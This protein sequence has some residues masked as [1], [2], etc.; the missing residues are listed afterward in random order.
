M[1]PK[2][3]KRYLNEE[4]LKD[5]YSSSR[6]TGL[7]HFIFFMVVLSGGWLVLDFSLGYRMEQWAL[8]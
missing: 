7:S 4:E 6:M 5:Y 1:A 3:A 8:N 2:K